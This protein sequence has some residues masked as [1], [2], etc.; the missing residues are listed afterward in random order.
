ML[1]EGFNSFTPG[2]FLKLSACFFK[3]LFVSPHQQEANK[4]FPKYK[5][6]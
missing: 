4:M 5:E 2:W 1:G 6:M 3:S